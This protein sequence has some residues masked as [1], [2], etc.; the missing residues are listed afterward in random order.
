MDDG[1][2]LRS[3]PLTRLTACQSEVRRQVR[4][5]NDGYM[6]DPS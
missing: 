2:S 4:I 3:I 5:Q 1:L 6:V